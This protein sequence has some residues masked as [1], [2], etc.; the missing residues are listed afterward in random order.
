MVV[1]TE[2][3]MTEGLPRIG[4][5]L[6]SGA[7]RGW[8]HIGVIKAL[9]EAGVEPGIVCGA[10]IGALVG[11]A[12]ASGQLEPFE[13]WVRR[14]T[15]RDVIRYMDV[16]LTGGGFIEGERLLEFA[17]RYAGDVQIESLPKA[18]SAVATELSKG[19][20]VWLQTGSLLDAVRASCALPGLFSPMNMG[21]R[22]LAD[23]GLVNPVPVSLCR[24]MGAE[25]VIAVNLN[26]D[27]VGRHFRVERP[28]SSK[29]STE[30]E[31]SDFLGRLHAALS[32][33]FRAKAEEMVSSLM[34]SNK[35]PG[36]FDVL[37]S[38]LNIMQDRITRSRMAGDPPDIM[39]APRLA[40]IGLLEF[41]QAEVAIASGEQAVNH[42]LPAI[43]DA[44]R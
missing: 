17:R 39:L 25:V 3:E 11:G 33:G 13:A 35:T 7:A 16:Q 10:S 30:Q 42:M 5:A 14:L 8:A 41:H 9:K 36:M 1:S 38:A 18:F 31:E 27:I 23:G 21:G 44:I 22:W 2:V 12:Y 24:A 40:H 29:A 4:L 6:G 19:Q 34:G 15:W 32:N 20:E 28:S 43:L 26:G 37:S